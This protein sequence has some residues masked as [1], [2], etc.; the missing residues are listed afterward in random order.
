[1]ILQAVN[2]DYKCIFYERIENY[3]KNKKKYV[4]FYNAFDIFD[5]FCTGSKQFK[6]D[7]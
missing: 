1:M 6:G 3:E 5:N 7:Y 4:T 2:E